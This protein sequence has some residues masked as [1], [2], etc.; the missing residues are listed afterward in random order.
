MRSRRWTIGQGALG[1]FI[2]CYDRHDL[3]LKYHIRTRSRETLLHDHYTCI[4]ILL[5]SFSFP[6][7]LFLEREVRVPRG[8]GLPEGRARS[9]AKI[10]LEMLNRGISSC[11]TLTAS[12]LA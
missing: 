4:R 7:F 9:C 11:V 1:I 2:D 3:T 5:F 8:N 10:W 12:P 6:P